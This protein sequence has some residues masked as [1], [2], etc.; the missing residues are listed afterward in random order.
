MSR[1][2]VIGI[3]KEFVQELRIPAIHHH[4]HESK[5]F[6]T[7]C[8]KN[9]RENFLS[10]FKDVLMGKS[11]FCHFSSATRACFSI[12]GSFVKKLSISVRFLKD[13]IL[14]EIWTKM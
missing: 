11:H 5:I 14:V 1:D 13:V 12:F 2:I 4:L 8:I 3:Y 10:N 7:S 9:L 6:I